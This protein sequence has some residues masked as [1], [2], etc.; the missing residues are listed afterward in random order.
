MSSQ[1]SLAASTS[2]SLAKNGDGSD[3][4]A[5]LGSTVS[6]GLTLVQFSAQRKRFLSDRGCIWGLFRGCLGVIG[7][8][9]GIFCV[10]NRSN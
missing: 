9:Q 7:G 1:P 2:E 6:Q 4:S 5:V 10:R 8:V 3:S